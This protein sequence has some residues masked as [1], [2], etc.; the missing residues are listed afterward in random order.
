MVSKPSIFKN[1]LAL[2]VPN[3]LNPIVSFILVLMISRYRG[4]E[5]LGEYSLVLSYFSVFSTIAALGLADLIVREVARNPEN[6]HRFLFNAGVF[7]TASSLVSLLLMNVV[8][9]LMGYEKELLQ[10]AFVCSLALVASTSVAYAEAIFRSLEKSEFV[11][12]TFI[13]EN[14]VR[15]VSCVLLLLYGY[16]MVALFLA[17]LGSRIFGFL[18]LFVFYVKVLGMPGM[19]LDLG[20]LRLL[21][22]E[23]ATFLSIAVFS[24][25]HLSLDEIMLSK[26]K[27]VE[28]VG[29][30]S[31]AGRLLHV[32][33]MVP[34]AYA[35]ALLPF[36]TKEFASGVQSLRVPVIKSLKYLSLGTLP[37]VFGTM[38]L[39]DNF[40]LLIYGGEFRT[41]IPV[42]RLHIVSLIPFSIAFILAQVLIATNNQV[43]DLKINIIAAGTNLL[44]NLA[45]I[46]AFAEIGAV[47]AT[48]I[49]IILFNELQIRYLR[50]HLFPIPLTSIMGRT[51]LASACMAGITYLLRDWNLFVNICISAMV[52]LLMVFLFGAASLEEMRVFARVTLTDRT[53]EE[54]RR[55]TSSE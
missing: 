37:V 4:V 35:A 46:P 8:V 52:Y 33:K 22:R 25:L 32:C 1:T 26:L 30:Y 27:S 29:I 43:V 18:L 42:L 51:L 10:A 6:V 21:V 55:E 3:I 11:A 24:T 36:F 34:V 5:G 48:L 13:I 2:S 41:S 20:V 49:T 14:V 23:S 45:L 31:A 15:V 38:I 19:T 54:N 16:G 44:L 53:K 7:G 39:A 28:A 47:L 17:I 40:I 50:K 12:A 9:W